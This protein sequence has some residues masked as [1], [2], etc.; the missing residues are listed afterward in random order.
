MTKGGSATGFTLLLLIGAGLLAAQGREQRTPPRPP[1]PGARE[2]GMCGDSER[3]FA[4]RPPRFEP[5]KRPGQFPPGGP[6]PG[7]VRSRWHGGG[8]PKLLFKL[9]EK[10]PEEQDR[11]LQSN[12]RFTSLPADEQRHFR[13]KLKRISAMTPE[14]RQSFR[15]RFEIFHSLPE[16][17]RDEIRKDVFPAWK[18]LAPE[19]RHAV[20]GEFRM[21]RKMPPAARERRF[22]QEPFGKQFSPE[23]QHL[24]RR[25][26]SLSSL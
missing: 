1:A 19:R 25:L 22:S 2:R 4:G 10:S 12:S 15:E 20:L 11:I 9:A 14:E 17:A 13:E 23:E 3:P 6:G 16:A 21:L 7:S 8:L 18:G 5:G 26:V 24:L